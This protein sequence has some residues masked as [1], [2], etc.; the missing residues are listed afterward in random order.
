MAVDRLERLTN[1]VA[2]LAHAPRPVTFADIVE[3]V[4]GYGGEKATLRRTFERDKALLREESGIVITVENDRYSIR[5]EDL[6]LPPLDLDDAERVALAI[7]VA[8][9]PVSEGRRA[10]R[11]LGGIEG[12]G[13]PGGAVRA[14][15]EELPFL[16]LLHHATRTRSVVSFTYG[17]NRRTVEPYGLLFRDGNWYLHGFDRDRSETRNFR[18]DRFGEDV[19]VG[20]AGS[21]ERPDEVD[22]SGAMPKE[23]WLI[24]GNDAFVARVRVDVAQAGKVA[25][26]VGEDRV[27]ERR[28]DGSVVLELPVTNRNGFRSWLL[29][30]FDHAEVMEPPELRQD[31][32][33]WL[34]DIARTVGR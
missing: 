20:E 34:Q 23:P 21:F 8:A 25:A 27:R 3:S 11:N 33:A 4:P 5:P 26:E 30:L 7:A 10:L 6:Y 19:E 17:E 13:E 9:V 2:Y 12:S 24:G 31:V 18:L 22:L 15:L 16:P 1:L 32:V 29:G 28:D 14:D